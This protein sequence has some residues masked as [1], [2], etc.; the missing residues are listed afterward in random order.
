[1]LKFFC[2]QTKGKG[3]CLRGGLGVKINKFTLDVLVL[4]NLYI[5]LT[6]SWSLP[7]FQIMMKFVVESH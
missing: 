4:S 2:V 6:L 5:C 1:M 7:K 3:R